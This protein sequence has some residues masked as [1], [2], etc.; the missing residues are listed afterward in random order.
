MK[1]SGTL[2]TEPRALTTTILCGAAGARNAGSKLRGGGGCAVVPY[3][4]TADDP[5]DE[6]QQEGHGDSQQGAQHAVE[7]VFGELEHSVAPDPDPVE[8]LRGARLCD[9][10]VKADLPSDQ[11][12]GSVTDKRGLNRSNNNTLRGLNRANTIN[13]LRGGLDNEHSLHEE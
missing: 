4:N 10:V 1:R 13:T 8:A 9:H 12:A 6:S 2:G 5:E 3:V 11:T 7:D